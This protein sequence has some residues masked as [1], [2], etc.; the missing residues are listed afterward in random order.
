MSRFAFGV[1]LLTG[2]FGALQADAT[3]TAAPLDACS[4]LTAEDVS[5]VVGVKVDTGV[6]H[7]EGETPDGAFSS[8]CI[9]K[10]AGAAPA[11]PDP[12][13]PFGGVAFAMLNTMNWP[14]GSGKA[15]KYLDDFYQA[16][17]DNLIDNTPVPVKVGDDALWW[18]DG[19]A[20]RKG[21]VSFGV[22]THVSADKARERVMEEALA[23]K[24][25]GR[26]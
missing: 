9:W 24:I 3:D 14:A 6:R 16:A 8:T 19:T 26:L 15:Q 22:S 12:E 21:D 7:D 13:K 23:K 25:V 1:A 10:V 18:G 5:A 11:V 2:L 4:L 20:V 17:K